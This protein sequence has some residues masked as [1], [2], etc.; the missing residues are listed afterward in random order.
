MIAWHGS[1]YSFAS[2]APPKETGNIRPSEKGRLVHLNQ[3]FV[4]T[5]ISL[6]IQYAREFAGDNGYLYEVEVP[7][8]A[9]TSLLESRQAK[10]RRKTVKSNPAIFVVDPGQCRIV[11]VWH[12]SHE[13][14][15]RGYSIWQ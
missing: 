7:K 6:A 5:D 9:C 3:T 14:R 10:G 4:T 11:D 1:Q 15:H 12:T 2:F 8:S 13:G